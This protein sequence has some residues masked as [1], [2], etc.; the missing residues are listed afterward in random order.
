MG[1][2]SVIRDVGETLKELLESI[3]W[4]DVNL[5]GDDKPKVLLKSPK[6]SSRK[7]EEKVIIKKNAIKNCKI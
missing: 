1:T 4:E 2:F 5:V 6:D 3:S 7:V